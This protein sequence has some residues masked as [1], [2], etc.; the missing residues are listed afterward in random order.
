[1]TGTTRITPI[2]AT[3]CLSIMPRFDFLSAAKLPTSSPS[4]SHA[5]APSL[6]SNTH[7]ANMKAS[8]S[9]RQRQR[10]ES[11]GQWCDQYPAVSDVMGLSYIERGY[12]FSD[13]PLPNQ[14]IRTWCAV[15]RCSSNGASVVTAAGATATGQLRSTSTRHRPTSP[16]PPTRSGVSTPRLASTT[17]ASFVASLALGWRTSVLSFRST[18]SGGW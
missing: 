9:P 12:W 14:P 17:S 15:A 5:A 7:Q 10:S 16:Q 6:I 2:R 1:M 13:N 11:V 3:P 4:P 18:T 8:T